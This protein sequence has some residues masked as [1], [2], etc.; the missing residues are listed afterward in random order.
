[1]TASTVIIGGGISGLATAYYLGKAGIASTLIEA[2]PKLGGVI[3]TEHVDGCVIEGGPDSFLSVK[4]A[5][6]DLI[7]DLGL[8]GEVIGSNDHLRV[9]YVWKGGSLVPMP[10]G[11]QLM[12]PTK[13]LPLLTTRLLSWS[14]KFRMGMELFHPPGRHPDDQSVAEFVTRHYG[15]QAVDYLAEPLL[16]GIFGGSPGALSVTSVLPRFVELE[17]KYGSLTKGVLAEMNAAK[18]QAKKLPLFRTLKG[19]LAVLVSA[20]TARIESHT[21]IVHARAL[22]VERA[23]GAFRIRLEDGSIDCATLVLACEAHNAA[24]LATGLDARLAEL[25]GSV[26]YSS[27]MTVALAFPDSAFP[28]PLRGFGFLVPKCERRRLVACTWVGTKFPHRAPPGLTVL[29][30]FLGGMDDAA[31][32]DESDDAIAAAVLDELHHIVGFDAQPLFRRIFRWPRSMAQYTVGHPQR[33][34]EIEAR[35]AAVAGLQLAGNAYQGIG[36]PD[37][38]RMG[39]QA[40]DAIAKAACPV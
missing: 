21:E 37:C 23:A 1:M 36:I 2:R 34:A 12:V 35:A 17:A 25:L 18:A 6:M 16:S 26:P 38:I 10:D 28:R 19:G 9:T 27:S 14:T 8:A 13:L 30:C 7:S 5:A 40:A 15:A 20:V 31:V 33:L 39:K 11:L 4:P 24:T 29:R 32:L 22:A 3:R